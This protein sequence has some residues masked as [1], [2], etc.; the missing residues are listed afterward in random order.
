M[1]H[2]FYLITFIKHN[3]K[4]WFIKEKKLKNELELLIY[5]HYVYYNKHHLESV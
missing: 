4:S 2:H 3:L 5:K 1:S